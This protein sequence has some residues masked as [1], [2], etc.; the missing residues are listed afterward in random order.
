MAPSPSRLAASSPTVAAATSSAATV[1][2]PSASP[3]AWEALLRPLELPTVAPGDACPTT[4]SS[5]EVEGIGPV[6]GDGPI[7]PAFLGP[8]G[9]FEIGTA[10]TEPIEVDG[11]D[12]WGRKTLWVSADTYRG[13]ALVRGAR[14]DRA[15]VVLFYPGSGREYVSAMRLTAEPWVRGPDTPAGWREW[16]SGVLFAEPGCFA[17]QIDGEGLTSVVVVEATAADGTFDSS[18]D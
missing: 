12:W 3:D 17:F 8:D 1:P 15:G 9:V 11:R 16:N 14:I 6:L 10:G 2:A 13:I 4:G 7:Y 5:T 18:G